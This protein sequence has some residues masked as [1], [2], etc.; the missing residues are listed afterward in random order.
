VSDWVSWEKSERYSATWATKK[1]INNPL[2]IISSPSF[3]VRF[4]CL[5]LVAIRKMVDDNGLG[6]QELAKFALDGI[7]HLQT[8]YVHRQDTMALT[9][10]A[11]RI[12]DYLTQAWAPIV[13]LHQAFEPWDL[14]RTGSDIKLVL[15][16]HR[17]SILELE[18]I[19]I[20]AEGVEE[21]D[22]HFTL[23][24]DTMDEITHK[25]MRRL[26]GVFF[27][28]SNPARPIMIS[29]VFDFPSGGT[30]PVPPQLIPPGRQIQRLCTLG[31]KLRDIIEERNT[32]SHEETLKSL[33]S[34]RNIP[35]SVRGLNYLM[36]RQLWRLLDL[37]D[38]GGLGFTIE[39]FF[40][41]LRQLELSS[42]SS[43][44]EVYYTGTFQAITS[45]W[46]K[47]KNS[48]GTQRILLDLLCDLAIGSRGA[49]SNFRYPPYIVCMLLELV[50]KMVEGHIGFHAHIDDIIQELEEVDFRRPMD[51]D[52][53][54]KA[55]NVICPLIPRFQSPQTSLGP[56]AESYAHTHPNPSPP[57]PDIQRSFTH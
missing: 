17:E 32:E 29:E 57:L 21:V 55:L 13:D 39:L 56:Q 25:L 22:W 16:S 10:I 15:N 36:K 34:L 1:K 38:G 27:N 54:D 43:S 18:R 45:D 52:L 41:T 33:E 37:R 20:E 8:D 48:V 46:K 31:R 6:L 42:M 35:V 50:G 5:S 3:A 51:N 11:Q 40:L 19:A 44:S 26:P 53:R 24:Q 4:T 12:D 2:K 47:S 7:A 30:T 28:E 14:N 49:F 23:L 9:A